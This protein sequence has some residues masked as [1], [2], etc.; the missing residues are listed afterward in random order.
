MGRPPIG[1]KAMMPGSLRR[2]LALVVTGNGGEWAMAENMRRESREQPVE[3]QR[4]R[5]LIRRGLAVLWRARLGCAEKEPDRMSQ[6]RVAPDGPERA[7]EQV[8]S[9]VQRRQPL[10]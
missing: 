7:G 1:K 6:R 5:G 10:A 4:E 2:G 8:S 3:P 9:V